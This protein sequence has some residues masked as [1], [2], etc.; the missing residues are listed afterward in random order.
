MGGLKNGREGGA[1]DYPASPATVQNGKQTGGGGGVNCNLGGGGWV[2][3][4]LK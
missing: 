3:R 4:K 2:G 1:T